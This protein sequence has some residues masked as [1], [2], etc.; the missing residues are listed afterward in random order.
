MQAGQRYRNFLVQKV[1]P[2]EELKCT[3]RELIH[4]PSGALIMHLEN[5]DPENLFCLSFETLPYNSNGVAHVLEHTVL[6]GSK[7]FPIKDPFFSMTRRS[8]S[9]FMNALTGA[10]VTCYPAAT[11]VEKDFYNL[12][13]VYLDAVFHPHLRKE[14]FLQEGHRLEFSD[15]EDPSTPLVFKGIVFNEMKGAFTA[16]ETRLW[17]ALTEAIMPD[18]TYAYVSG[19]DPK[20]IPTLT[21][22]Q[23]LAF[24]EIY[25]HP[26]R[27]LFFFY[28][29]LRLEKHL[30]FIEEKTLSSVVKKPPLPPLPLQPRFSAP[31]Y[32]EISYPALE[33]EDLERKTWVGCVWLT[34]AM[35]DQET[36]LALTVL[37]AVLMETDAS[38][39][40][41]PLLQSG[42]CITAD[43]YL[44]TEMS[45][46]PYVII[47]KGCNH[48]DAD[49]LERLVKKTLE[50]I[51]L[52]GI[53]FHL[54]EAAI[55]Q[56]EFSR[57]EIT[58]DHS[59]YGLTLFMR[60]ALA[61][62]HGCPPENGLMI[63][64][65]FQK[66]L[67]QAR[68]PLYFP[69]LIKKYL[70]LNP[71]F[72]KVVMTPDPTLSQRE[73]EEEKA[74]LREIQ[75]KLSAAEC[76]AL[77]R[78]AKNLER[79]QKEKEGQNLDCLPKVT[80]S[81]VPVLVRDFALETKENVF[82]HESFTNGIV[83]ADVVIDLPSF[84]LEDLPYV[85]LLTLM[86]PELGTGGRSY[87]E[88]LEYLQAYTGGV[89]AGLSL[90]VQT[91]TPSTMS[92]CLTIRGKALAR[93]SE[94]LFSLLRDFSY[95]VRLDETKR[96]E[97]ILLQIHSSLQNKLNKNAL[98]YAT[99]LATS[100][101]S[102]AAKI[103]E[104]WS[105]LS[106]FYFIDDLVKKGSPK[107]LA[108]KLSTVQKQLTGSPTLILGCDDK[109]RTR[110][111]RENYF[112]LFD[113]PQAQ[114]E[115]WK[116]GYPLSKIASQGRPI[117]APVAFTC[118]AYAAPTYLHPHAPALSL[119]T[120]I[121][122]NKILHPK[123]REQG[124]AYGSGATYAPMTGQMTLH[125]YR[126][127]HVVKTVQAF[128]EAIE[129]TASGAFDDRD[130]E[131]AKL[132]MIQSLDAPVA[133]GS[134]AS[135]AYAWFRDGKT[136]SVRQKYRNA[137][138][139]MSRH[140]VARAVEKELSPQKE[141]SV[142]VAFGG[143]ELLEKENQLMEKP[144]PIIPI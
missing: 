99:L 73:E 98:R 134:R 97:E 127:P 28:G 126:D 12:L 114:K 56:L 21:Y 67:T 72:A 86:L 57:T 33:V 120:Q 52:E 141:S 78:Q 54:I 112:G 69:N 19:G 133:P 101:L 116:G 82:F 105:G 124:G 85:Q 47:F 30:D 13:D 64:T 2:I 9:T 74:R 117:A 27:C 96:V 83:Y 111:E 29:N 100:G 58:G 138:L 76:H 132:G 94:K 55:H 84:P 119:A 65:L 129:Q 130:L 104:I 106:F 51:A 95:E 23:L 48:K 18:L 20:A 125:S 40:K 1:L 103:T 89:T 113:L 59:P 63:H 66:L 131:D 32:R 34:V 35:A 31:V 77:V 45:E 68:D 70:L 22:E 25:Y 39:L 121:M 122:E 62:Q 6:C 81:D 42:L 90:H 144:L 41:L 44:D 123:I 87:T 43:A 7:K 109:A 38:P 24:H 14:S 137:L 71:H 17:Q 37:D 49:K 75:E 139:E 60:S 11:Q 140:E 142:I 115:P 10:D 135:L 79:Y 108:E 80:L 118:A 102:E 8:L 16:P 91:N 4:E 107:R 92:P 46:V 61:K 26:S 36:L 93:K 50:K 136:A 3:L 88:T 128:R 15:P 143:K 53:P 110:I 5:D